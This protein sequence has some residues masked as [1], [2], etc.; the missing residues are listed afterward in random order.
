MDK[1]LIKDLKNIKRDE[2][3]LIKEIIFKYYSNW[4]NDTSLKIIKKHLNNNTFDL[5][6]IRK[7]LIDNYSIYT[8]IGIRTA[9]EIKSKELSKKVF[10]QYF[11]ANWINAILMDNIAVLFAMHNLPTCTFFSLEKYIQKLKAIN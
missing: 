3:Y 5:L 4:K 11:Q 8:E 2:D 10:N 7:N 6:S 1:E 9:H